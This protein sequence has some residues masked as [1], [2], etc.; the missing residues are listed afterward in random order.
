MIIQNLSAQP[1]F[2]TKDGSTI[3]TIL[4]RTNAPVRTKAS[5]KP[6]SPAGAATQ[7]HYHRLAEEFYFLLDGTGVMEIDGESPAPS[8]PA[9]PSSSPRRLAPDHGDHPAPLPLLLRPA[10]SHDD[11]YFQ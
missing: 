1:P 11:V 8:P 5:P 10:L 4:D 9:T 2:T 3:R 7:R 6:L